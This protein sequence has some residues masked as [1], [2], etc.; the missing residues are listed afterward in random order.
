MIRA[1]LAAFPGRR[2]CGAEGES[3]APVLMNDLEQLVAGAP[4][5]DAEHHDAR[6]HVEGHV[7]VEVRDEPSGR[8]GCEA[9]A[10]RSTPETPGEG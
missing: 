1:M 6:A 3:A 8:I 2:G 10:A 9:A 5:D 4:D 7:D